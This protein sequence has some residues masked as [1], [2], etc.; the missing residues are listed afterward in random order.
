MLEEAATKTARTNLAPIPMECDAPFLKIVGRIAARAQRHALSQR[1]QS[2]VR[3]TRRALVRRRRHAARLPSRERPRQLPQSLGPHPEMAGRARRRPRAVRR[4]RPQAAGCA[5]LDD[6]GWRR[7]QHQH[8]LPCRPA[9]GAGG[10]PSADRD[11]ARHARRR[12]AIATMA[13][14]SRGPFTAHPKIDPG[15]RR[16]GVLRLQRRGPADPC[17]VL[18]VRR[19]VRRGDALRSLRGA[20]CQ[21]GARLHRHRKSSAVSDPA[22]HRQ[23]GAR[24]ARPAA[25]RLGA[26]QGRLCR[27]HEAQRLGQRYRL[28]SRRELLRL[29]RH[30]CVGGRRP[31]RR[32]RHAVRGSA[33]VHPSR[34]LA[35]RS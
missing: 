26:G 25:L 27:R 4:L 22:H 13:A 17:P 5:G 9:A 11:R 24:D 28:V 3:R 6:P 8:H 33:A 19:R 35:D 20:L 2:A 10:S 29:P 30:E 1:P 31:H 14:A 12:A 7:R 32:R 21:H 34:R 16:D 18:R 23:H 15:H